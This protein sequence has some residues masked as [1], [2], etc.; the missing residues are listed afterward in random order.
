MRLIHRSEGA[1]WLDSLLVVLAVGLSV[2][3]LIV[4]GSILESNERRIAAFGDSLEARHLVVTSV[5]ADDSAFRAGAD[6]RRLGS[7]YTAQLRF[8]SEDVEAALR[9]APSVDCWYRTSIQR[10][11]TDA[12]DG[13]IAGFAVTPDYL[14]AARVEV[15]AGSLP[16]AGDFAELRPVML[17]TRRFAAALELEGDPIGQQVHFVGEAAPY[18]IVGIL[19]S[20]DD[21]PISIREAIVPLA[22]GDTFSEMTFAVEDVRDMPQAVAEMRAFASDRWG[23]AATVLARADAFAGY[24][25]ENRQRNLATAVLAT[26]ALLVSASNVMGLLLARAARDRFRIGMARTFGASKLA[27][28]RRVLLDAGALGTVGGLMGVG[29]SFVLLRVYNADLARDSGNFQVQFAI[30]PVVVVIALAVALALCLV[31]AAYPAHAAS[32]ASIVSAIGGA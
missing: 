20:R 21:Q 16:T 6:A 25:L 8:T 1:R 10:F 19:P 22:P 12:W 5:A 31:A 11:D 18:T 24:L 4:A 14:D 7:V 28:R 13:V 30:S 2:A 3:V 23:D 27:V 15:V 32:R 29:A 9:A 26:A 17:V